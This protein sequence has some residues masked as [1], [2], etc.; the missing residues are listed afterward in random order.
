MTSSI[1]ALAL[2]FVALLAA[3]LNSRAFRQRQDLRLWD[4]LSEGERL[5]RCLRRVK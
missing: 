5:A 4:E 1:V 3:W 2:F